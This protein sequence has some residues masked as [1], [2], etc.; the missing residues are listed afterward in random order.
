MSKSGN[1][2][3]HEYLKI[4]E[5]EI[6]PALE[7]L[8]GKLEEDGWYCFIGDLNPFDKMQ[9]NKEQF[10]DR[11]SF[12]SL[13]IMDIENGIVQYVFVFLEDGRVRV[14]CDV[15]KENK[16]VSLALTEISYRLVGETVK[17]IINS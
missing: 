14:T 17:M 13:S 11:H 7:D 3:L 15:S 12:T 10:A 8:R 1:K 6:L 4:R 16:G 9:D 5:R 2:F